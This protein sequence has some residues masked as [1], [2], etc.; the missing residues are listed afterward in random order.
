MTL[1][2][3]SVP[4]DDLHLHPDNKRRGNV[5]QV[6]ASLEQHGQYK[7][8]VVQQSTMRVL[9][10]NHTL[11]AARQL[12]WTHVDAVIIDVDDSQALRILLVDNKTSD[13]AGYDDRGLAELLDQLAREEGLAGTGFTTDE[14]QELAR[15]TGLLSDQA[16]G[17]LDGVGTEQEPAPA[18]VGPGS[19]YHT[20][21]WPVTAPQRDT[22]LK[23]LHHR[24]AQMPEGATTI[25]ALVQL[26][27]DYNQAQDGQA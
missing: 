8:I 19:E 22:V 16:G 9:A 13:D 11:Q 14:A 23:A 17:F 24:R 20:L 1:T 3:L 2:S 12:G 5:E 25:D 18:G 6:Q 10:G 7:P 15:V 26:A 21:S 27:D 4:V